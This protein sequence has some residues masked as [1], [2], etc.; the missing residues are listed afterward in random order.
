MHLLALLLRNILAVRV[1]NLN[2]FLLLDV[3]TGV[4]GVLLTGAR[5]LHPFLTSITVRLPTRLAVRLLLTATL[6]LCV[7]LGLLSVLLAAHLLVD[8]LTGVLVDCL[9]GLSELLNLL[10][11]AFLLCL[12]N[13]LCVPDRL[14]C[15]EAGD[16]RGCL[17]NWCLDWGLNWGSSSVLRLPQYKRA[18]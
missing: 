17:N 10:L 11:V 15:G 4:V 7:R 2:Q 8:G 16:L 12:L 9:T 6:C 18:A 14:L 13:I 1:R 5:I 3:A